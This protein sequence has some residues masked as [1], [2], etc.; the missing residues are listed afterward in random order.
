MSRVRRLSLL[1]WANHLLLGAGLFAPCMTVTPHLGAIDDLARWLGL[2]DAPKTYSVATG[3]LRLLSGG[4]VAIGLVLLAFSALFPVSKLVVLRAA[5]ADACRGRPAGRAHDL[6]ARFGR[7]SMADVFVLALVVVASKSF[8]GGTTVDIRWGA[9]AFAA[10]A[11]LSLA[12]GVRVARLTA[13][14][15]RDG[16][17]S[18]APRTA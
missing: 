9:F 2:V 12:L 3:I 10:A 17:G 6:A 13:P 1:A 16:E 7:Y 4:N 14:S 18:P 8:P 5:L 15:P 11:L